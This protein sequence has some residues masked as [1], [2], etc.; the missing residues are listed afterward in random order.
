MSGDGPFFILFGVNVAALKAPILL[1][2]LLVVW[3]LW[4]GLRREQGMNALGTALAILPF[5]LPG[6]VT[7]SRLV[8]HAGGNIEPFVFVMAAFL[9]RDRAIAL[10]L[11]LALG[12]LNREFTAISG[13]ALVLVD[14][15]QG[16]SRERAKSWA[17][18]A[19]VATACAL[20][21][22]FVGTLGAEFHGF[23]PS[24]GTPTPSNF[25]GLFEQQLPTLI[26]VARKHS[27][28]S[29]YELADCWSL[30]RMC[31]NRVWLV[32]LCCSIVLSPPTRRELGGLSTYLILVGAGQSLAFALFSPLAR[33]DAG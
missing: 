3:M 30:D 31:G 26:E 29:I 27:A 18:A 2:N 25:A 17:I 33:H 28:A 4:R 8:E 23:T 19:A 6:V 5:A 22:R 9:L 10:G 13:I 14:V 16:R 7:A 32:V 20:V 24:T 12:F 21:G 15:L 1:L 11:V